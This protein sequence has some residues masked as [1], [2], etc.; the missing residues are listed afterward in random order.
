MAAVQAAAAFVCGDVVILGCDGFSSLKKYNKKNLLH[1]LERCVYLKLKHFFFPFPPVPVR[2]SF[3]CFSFLFPSCS[4][5][6]GCVFFLFL[7]FLLQRENSF[8]HSAITLY[9]YIFKKNIKL[10]KMNRRERKSRRTKMFAVS[11]RRA[12]RMERKKKESS[13][14]ASCIV[15]T[16][17]RQKLQYL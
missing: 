14:F 10:S 1:E 3:S 16:K 5:R 12:S 13:A 9:I 8:S 4:A 2:R 7:I 11:T 6:H 15:D 17:L